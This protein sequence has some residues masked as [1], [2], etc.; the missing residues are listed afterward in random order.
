MNC[1]SNTNKM[2]N[3][4][5]SSSQP[6]KRIPTPK[7]ILNFHPK[8][9]NS[10]CLRLYLQFVTWQNNSR[11]EFLCWYHLS[12]IVSQIKHAFMILHLI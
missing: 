7:D 4:N 6:A 11:E 8:N 10:L 3:K 9:K 5:H 1:S 2:K 12:R